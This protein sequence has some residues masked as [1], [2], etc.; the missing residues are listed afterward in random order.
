[1]ARSGDQ[2][3]A[4]SAPG[5]RVTAIAAVRRVFAAGGWAPLAV[6]LLHVVI[7]RGFDGYATWPHGDVPMHFLGGVAM[8][9]FLARMVRPL[10]PATPG[11]RTLLLE[12]LLA[13]GLTVTAAVVWE[14]AEFALDHAAGTNLQVS[15]ANT[16]QDLALG[17][18]GAAAW[19]GTIVSRA[20]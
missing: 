17:I 16:M 13:G 15:L 11:A 10:L 12:C 20:R 4:T 19:L 18:V 8:C 9:F 6:F 14:F 2:P 7:D 3:P 5:T 1:M